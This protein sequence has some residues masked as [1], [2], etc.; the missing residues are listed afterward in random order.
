[1]TNPAEPIIITPASVHEID[2]RHMPALAP[3]KVAPGASNTPLD[4][5]LGPGGDLPPRALESVSLINLGVDLREALL[6]YRPTAKWRPA[7]LGRRP[8]KGT[9]T[10]VRLA[11]P[12]GNPLA[13][14]VSECE[15]NDQNDCNLQH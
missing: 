7:D 3:V 4:T 5:R 15:S 14:T 6:Q 9:S 8:P 10:S 2:L 1:T 13:H 12:A 11:S